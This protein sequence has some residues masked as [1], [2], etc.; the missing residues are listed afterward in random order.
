MN[1]K[2]ILFLGKIEDVKKLIEQKRPSAE[3]ARFV[4]VKY[5][6]LK[7]YFNKYGINYAG[8]PNRSGF[9]HEESRVPLSKILNNE[10]TYSNTSLR[11]RLIECGL[12]EKKCECC[13]ITDWNGKEIQF[14]LHHID[15][16]HYNNNLDNLQILCPNCHS[17]TDT[18][19][20]TKTFIKK[21]EVNS[22]YSN[23]DLLEKQT[24]N[25]KVTK[26]KSSKEES[27]K[28]FCS[29]CGKEL[30]KKGQIKY[31]SYE[32]TRKANSKRPE[33]SELREILKVNNGNKSAVSRY[34]NVSETAVRKWMNLYGVK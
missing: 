25:K 12:K 22:D 23:V 15:G 21:K 6:T 9:V 31:C 26:N 8:N 29:Y 7:T 18:F 34:Y 11:K 17:Q 19:R 4:G 1:S 13:G 28:R 32:C 10:V 2:E 27:I 14:E 3:I 30:T 16:N 20:K 24:K 33:L 5:E